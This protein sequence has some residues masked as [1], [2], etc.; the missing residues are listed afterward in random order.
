MTRV[1]RALVL[2]CCLSLLWIVL[3]IVLSM[4]EDPPLRLLAISTLVFWVVLGVLFRYLVW[5]SKEER[6]AAALQ[7]LPAYARRFLR[8]VPIMGKLYIFTGAASFLL[9]VTT[10]RNK[11]IFFAVG[12][13]VWFFAA[14]LLYLAKRTKH[15]RE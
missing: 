5:Q 14:Y 2:V 10:E 15:L 7:P 4:R 3:I 6:H 1:V 13:V 12:A 9:G 11:E 8:R